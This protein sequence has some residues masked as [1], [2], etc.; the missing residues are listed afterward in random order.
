LHLAGIEAKGIAAGNTVSRS[1]RYLIRSAAV[2]ALAVTGFT[3]LTGCGN[4]YRPVVSAINPVGPS[5]QPQKYAVV[6]SSPSATSPGLVTIVDFSGDTVLITANIG[7]SPQYL[8]LNAAGNTGYTING[9]GTLNVFDIST[10]LITSQI[11]ETTLLANAAPLSI[12]PQGTNTYVTERGRNAIGQF[13]SATS[14]ALSLNQEIPVTN[15][16][17]VVGL[18]GAPR[19]YA[20]SQGSSSSVAGQAI[21]IDTTT[22]TPTAT[23]TV[24]KNPVYG[25]MTTDGKRAFVLNQGDGTVSV[26]NVQTNQLD[27]LPVTAGG[28]STIPVGV[29]PLWADFAPT[30]SEMV[31]ANAGNG[32]SKGTLSIVSIPLCN[33]TAQ[34]TNP[35][36]SATNPVDANGFG[37]VLAT[38]PVGISPVMVSALQDGTRAYVANRGNPNIACATQDSNGVPTTTPTGNCSVSVVNLTTNTVTATIPIP[39]RP[40]YIAATTGA[41]TGKVYVVCGKDALT[42]GVDPNSQNMTVI[43]TDTDTI[44]TTIPLQG[45]GVAVRVTAQ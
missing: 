3:S 1:A 33:A 34:G 30:L 15:P 32:T 44:D 2:A 12:F 26:V 42:S 35:L 37:T 17:Y 24:G 9:D 31:V 21:A 41:P 20:L 23:L 36:C 39:G 19:V 22:N 10:T 13:T 27:T 4:T 18:S 6:I 11:L 16:I 8:V 28:G 29:G 14:A 25:I 40:L 5:S 7:A 38:V 43:R 45:T